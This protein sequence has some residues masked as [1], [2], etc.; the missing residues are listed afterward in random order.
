[1]SIVVKNV[2]LDTEK[3]SV[4]FSVFSGNGQ[5]NPNKFDNTQV[6]QE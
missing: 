3:R 1:M 2:I 4:S 6:P 5:K